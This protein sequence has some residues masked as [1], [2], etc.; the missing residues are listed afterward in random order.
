MYGTFHDLVPNPLPMQTAIA[1]RL[2]CAA[3][4]L[5]P[6]LKQAKGTARNTKMPNLMKVTC[7]FTK[8]AI[9]FIIQDVLVAIRPAMLHEFE[10]SLS[11]EKTTPSK[12]SG[13]VCGACKNLFETPL[14]CCRVIRRG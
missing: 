4:A 6:F 11:L 9:D 10:R 14:T 2:R 7:L 12:T 5:V 1:H 8:S 13:Q 3:C